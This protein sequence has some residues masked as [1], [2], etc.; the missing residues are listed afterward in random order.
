MK[1]RTITVL[2]YTVEIH[3]FGY[4]QYMY[5]TFNGDAEFKVNKE[6]Y[7]ILRSYLRRINWSDRLME[8]MEVHKPLN[9]ILSL[10]G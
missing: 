10:H 1:T 5:P 3:D 4:A 6:G 7:K 2:G 8:E 9:I